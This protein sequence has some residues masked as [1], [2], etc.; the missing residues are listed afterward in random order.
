[1]QGLF[2]DIPCIFFI[3]DVPPAYSVPYVELH[4]DQEEQ[5]SPPP[6]CDTDLKAPPAYDQL[7]LHPPPSYC[8]SQDQKVVGYILLII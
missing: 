5:K 4:I 6:Y 2:S 1:M 3:L 7:S 8:Q